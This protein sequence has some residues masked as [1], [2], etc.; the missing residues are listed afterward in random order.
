[1]DYLSIII[2]WKRIIDNQ[3]KWQPI[4][5]PVYFWMDILDGVTGA[6]WDGGE[7]Q[8]QPDEEVDWRSHLLCVPECS[9][10]Q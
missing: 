8:G 1:M 6:N 10:G 7:A 4:E 3:V 9:P 2:F 5:P